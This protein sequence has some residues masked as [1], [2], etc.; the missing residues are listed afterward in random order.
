MNQRL[1]ISCLFFAGCTGSATVTAT[2]PTIPPPP[3]P[4]TAT[5]SVG[6]SATPAPPPPPPP[7]PVAVVTVTPVAQ[8]HP[9][10]LHALT[11]LRHARAWLERPAGAVVKWDENR[12]IR[13]IDA[14]INELKHAS[15]DDGKPM[16][17]HPPIDRPTWGGRL[18]RALEL[19][20][21]ARN[22]TAQEEDNG[23]A[24]GLR[25][26]AVGHID[27]AARDIR[28]G[29]ADQHV[30]PTVVVAAPPP[31]PPPTVVVATAP[32]P[33]P[34]PGA[35]PAYLHA[36]SDLRAARAQL[37]RPANVVVKWDENKAIRE[38]DAAINEI[39][40]AAIDDGKPLEDHPP[41]DQPT[42]GGRLSRCLEL[43]AQA[44]RDTGEE[45]DN[46]AIRGLRG[47]AEK[48]MAEAERFIRDGQAEARA[49]HEQPAPAVVVAPPPPGPGAHPAYLHALSDLR[50][51][52]A[53]LEKP[54]QPEVKWDESNGIRE[55]DAAI[56]EIKHAAIDDGKPLQD[57]PAI[58]AKRH[59][60]DRLREAETLLHK[61]AQDI[62]EHEDN[63]WAQGLRARA[64]GHIRQAE[65]AVHEAQ[66]DRGH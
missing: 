17:D 2:G 62:D 42:W 65:H 56:N 61:A 9:A 10:Y 48:H 8:A 22:D 37:Q 15:I 50:Y 53:L 28:E 21:Q 27:L 29:M 31:P 64:N 52:R 38:L 20:E 40:H 46:G 33:P 49:M 58:D 35:H 57:H 26:R 45:E 18:Q 3:P 60:R 16:S 5:V 23:W 59:H 36:L 6:V 34:G 25:N 19:V 11:D 51:A 54:A 7:A 39:K 14:A 4:P 12:A 55:I 32:P 63:G 66:A 13:E 30:Q 1:L 24:T 43:I 41:V 44:R 47:R